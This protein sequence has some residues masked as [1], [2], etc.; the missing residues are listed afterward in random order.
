MPDFIAPRPIDPVSAGIG[1]DALG[2]QGEAGRKA[3][4][5]RAVTPDVVSGEPPHQSKSTSAAAAKDAVAV[6]PSSEDDFTRSAHEDTAFV[7][8][9][10]NVESEE[11]DM[12]K[13]SRAHEIHKEQEALVTQQVVQMIETG[14]LPPWRKPWDSEGNSSLPTNM[15]TGNAYS[16]SNVVM[17]WVARYIH[18]YRTNLWMTLRQANKLGGHVVTGAKGTP[19][20]YY[21]M[22]PE[23]DEH[24]RETGELV[25]MPV[26]SKVFNLDQINGVK[27]LED[28]LEKLAR[29]PREGT[30]E[31]TEAVR[32]LVDL[33]GLK[34][35]EGFDRALYSPR[36]DHIQMPE[37][38]R[39]T[40]GFVETLYHEL[41]HS[42][43]HEK[44][45]GRMK[46][47]RRKFKNFTDEERYAYEELV[48]EMAACFFCARLG[49]GYELETNAAYLC[50]WLEKMKG[51]PAYL[52]KASA[53]ASRVMRYTDGIVEKNRKAG[54]ARSSR[55][56]TG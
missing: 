3:T 16:G 15:S 29:E 53:D 24:G 9:R 25:P 51:D 39:D 23:K 14:G 48:A 49:R 1:P 27:G 11:N 8:S 40:K 5:S 31:V 17:L 42:T 45:L 28:L 7:E 38:V 55:T 10:G 30:E 46:K 37:G 12:G 35:Y 52:F 4:A 26:W 21:D 2:R 22:I 33:T 43:G 34:A 41:A 32:A 13:K 20:L 50:G 6:S 18:E 19:V 54:A 44:R 56:K 36:G 47:T